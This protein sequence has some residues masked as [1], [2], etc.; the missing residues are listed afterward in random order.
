MGQGPV[1]DKTSNSL[2]QHG[3][4]MKKMASRMISYEVRDLPPR[5]EKV[6]CFC[7][8]EYLFQQPLGSATAKAKTARLRVFNL[9]KSAAGFPD[10]QICLLIECVDGVPTILSS[11]APSNRSHS[12]GSPGHTTDG[13]TWRAAKLAIQMYGAFPAEGYSLPDRLFSPHCC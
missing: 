4:T 8:R 6:N 10:E 12:Q 9:K 7:A 5:A 2:E 11:N 3:D 13:S 1:S